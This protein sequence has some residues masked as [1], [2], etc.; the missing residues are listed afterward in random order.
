MTSP[1]SDHKIKKSPPKTI[2]E[3]P[4]MEEETARRIAEALEGIEAALIAQLFENRSSFEANMNGL[5]TARRLV[6]HYR[7]VDR[8][9]SWR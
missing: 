8:K 2:M 7:A 3:G 4:P 9:K 5:D 6:E 1:T